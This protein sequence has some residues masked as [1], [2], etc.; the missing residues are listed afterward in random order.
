MCND[1]NEDEDWCG[2]MQSSEDK[3]WDL[4]P[5]HFFSLVADYLP[6]PCKL[7]E[8]T[9]YFSDVLVKVPRTN[10]LLPGIISIQK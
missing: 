9:N 3:I 7:L 8:E 4:S 5:I 1:A 2:T 6:K 10:K